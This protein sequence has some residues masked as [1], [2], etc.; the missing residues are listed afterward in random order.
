MRRIRLSTSA[1]RD[2]RRIKDRN[3]GIEE[4]K[5]PQA[6]MEGKWHVFACKAIVNR[7]PCRERKLLMGGRKVDVVQISPLGT[8]GKENSLS[9]V[10]W[11]C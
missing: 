4:P 6:R 7:S 5:T 10:Y 9:Q 11:A 1:L 3:E 8:Q 2:G